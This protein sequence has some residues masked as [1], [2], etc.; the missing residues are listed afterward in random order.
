MFSVI[1]EA[2]GDIDVRINRT[3]CLQD[4]FQYPWN[5]VFILKLV[6]YCQIVLKLIVTSY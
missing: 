4:D 5:N 6:S 3:I 1:L 2:L